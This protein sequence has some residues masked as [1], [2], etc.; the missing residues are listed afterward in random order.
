MKTVLISQVTSNGSDKLPHLH[1]LDLADAYTV[2][3]P[4]I[5]QTC[6][7]DVDPLTPHFFINNWGLQG[8]PFFPYFCSTENIDCGY[9]LCFE[10]KYENS[11][12]NSNE[13]CHFYSREKSLYVAWACFR[14]DK[15]WKL[16]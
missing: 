12:K 4:N 13:N 8:Y 3:S 7:C 15:C 1:S 16:R 11:Q 14:N 2:C 5:M 6:L 10:Q 9:N